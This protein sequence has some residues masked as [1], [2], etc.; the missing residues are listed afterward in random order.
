MLDS[1]V[2]YRASLSRQCERIE[3]SSDY[4]CCE[5]SQRSLLTERLL[6]FRGWRRRW[7]VV[8]I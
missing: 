7:S 5:C 1:S 2:Q 3:F 8:R 6:E 4:C